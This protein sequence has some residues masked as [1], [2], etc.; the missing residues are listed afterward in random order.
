M[1]FSV[2]QDVLG[3][4]LRSNSCGGR[5]AAT[6]GKEAGKFSTL[7]AHDEMKSTQDGVATNSSLAPMGNL[8]VE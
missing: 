1:G 6:L 5:R 4:A 3:N 8:A 2:Y 7:V